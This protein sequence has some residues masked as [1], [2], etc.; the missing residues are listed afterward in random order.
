MWL[1]I[2]VESVSKF[3]DIIFKK[4][5]SDKKIY[6]KSMWLL[7]IYNYLSMPISLS[8]NYVYIHIYVCI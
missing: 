7:I 1:I 5:N 8:K 2:L 3:T 4:K 6:D